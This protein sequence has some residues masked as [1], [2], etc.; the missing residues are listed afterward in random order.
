M[1]PLHVLFYGGMG[2]WWGEYPLNVLKLDKGPTVAGG[3][4]AFLQTA[5]GLARRGHEVVACHP[6]QAGTYRGVTFRPRRDFTPVLLDGFEPDAVVSWS[7]MRALRS[8]AI[9]PACARLFA[10]QLNDLW[11]GVEGADSFVS[12]SA[13]HAG[14]LKDVAKS[15]GLIL[16]SIHTAC[17]GVTCSYP[18]AA[19]WPREPIVGYWSSPDRGLTHILKV[20]PAVHRA[21]QDA[22]LH[23]FYEIDRWAQV[24]D[25]ASQS[26]GHAGWFNAQPTL[27]RR[28]LEKCSGLGVRVFG[29]MARRALAREQERCRIFCYPLDNGGP[30]VEGFGCALLEG[31]AAGCYPIV[32]LRDALPSVYEGAKGDWINGED[33][34]RESL[35]KRLSR[36]PASD[37]KGVNFEVADKYTWTRAAEEMEQ[38][39][40]KTL[41]VRRGD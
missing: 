41:E 20:W 17:S 37:F 38:A 31:L 7:Y 14:F 18:N 15:C 5:F 40:V 39:I 11:Q 27:I 21:V 12:P 4:A 2:T 30:Y 3:E 8:P 22:R 10:Q 16:P 36:A 32:H 6:G 23:V 13:S 1:S 9:P 25:E 35:I 34:L 19:T 29:A 28:L 24:C 26:G 33:E